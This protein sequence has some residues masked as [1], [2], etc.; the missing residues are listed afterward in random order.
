MAAI[1]VVVTG[2]APGDDAF[3]LR[4]WFAAEP[5][6]AGRARV[7]DQPPEDGRLGSIAEIVSLLLEPAGAVSVFAG[8]LVT[9]LRHR[10]GSAKIT[11]RRED[12]TEISLSAQRVKALDG[13]SLRGVVNELGQWTSGGPDPASLRELASGEPSDS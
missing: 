7:L 2:E 13:E 4:K 1:S 9:W 5:E 12:G 8:V 11:I 6:L 3:G 10:T